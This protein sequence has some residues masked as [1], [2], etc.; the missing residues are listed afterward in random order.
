VYDANNGFE[1]GRIGFGQHAVTQVEDVT[2]VGAGVLQDLAGRSD[3]EVCAIETTG[4]IEVALNGATTDTTTT[5]IE[6]NVP[7][8]T[9]DVG[10]R[11]CHEV[12]KFASANTKQDGR[13][14]EIGDPFENSL[15]GG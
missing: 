14:I 8:N 5:F 13:Y 15:G 12:K 6:V 9:H 10:I 4:R 1:N 7:V 11:G 3:S 2:G